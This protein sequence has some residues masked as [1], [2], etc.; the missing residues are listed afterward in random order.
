MTYRLRI[1]DDAADLLLT[2]AKWYAGTSQSL[3]VAA[4]WYDGFLDVL[5][6]LKSNPFRGPVA[7]ENDAFDF[8]L[9]EI[10]YGS[11]KRPTHRALY[12]IAGEA[13]EVLSIRHHAQRPLKPGDI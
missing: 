6:S 9:R 10:H 12:R 8:E 3:E 2:I 5:D 13:V 11:G 1:T 4:A 7:P